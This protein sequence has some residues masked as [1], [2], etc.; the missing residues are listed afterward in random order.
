LEEELAKLK[1]QSATTTKKCKE[2]K[3]DLKLKTDK[4]EQLQKDLQTATEN[5]KS[6]AEQGREQS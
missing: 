5:A 4:I 1:Q 6:N 3:A 2:L